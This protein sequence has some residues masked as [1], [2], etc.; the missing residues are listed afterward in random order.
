LQLA[1]LVTRRHLIIADL[2]GKV[3]GAGLFHHLKNLEIAD[4]E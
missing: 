4:G 3:L 2:V 1:L